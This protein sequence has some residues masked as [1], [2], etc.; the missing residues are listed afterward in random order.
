ML[1]IG[2]NVPAEQFEMSPVDKLFVRMGARDHIMAG[3]STFL[4]EM[5]ETAAMLVS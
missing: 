5:S 2:A 3:Q 4:V 1:Q